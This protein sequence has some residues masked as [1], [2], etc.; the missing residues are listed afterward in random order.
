MAEISSRRARSKDWASDGRKAAG[1]VFGIITNLST[2]AQS[3]ALLILSGK[4]LSST[5]SRYFGFIL[6]NFAEYITLD[7]LLKTAHFRALREHFQISF[8]QIVESRQK[9]WENL[10]ANHYL[11][12]D[13]K[14]VLRNGV[15]AQGW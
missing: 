6:I 8:S 5:M 3:F 13:Y 10:A 7:G 11:V 2:A 14:E 12:F 15:G 9:Q 1:M 4:Y